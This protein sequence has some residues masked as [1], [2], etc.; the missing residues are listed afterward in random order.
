MGNCI[1]KYS[2]CKKSE[3]YEFEVT[4]IPLAPL[5]SGLENTSTIS[6]NSLKN[7]VVEAKLSKKIENSSVETV[8]LKSP[9][10]SFSK[11]PLRD[12]GTL[13]LSK[14]SPANIKSLSNS[15]NRTHPNSQ[16]I[17]T[18][19]L[20]VNSLNRQNNNHPSSVMPP[21]ISNG[22]A[23]VMVAIFDYHS[24]TYEELSLRKGEKVYVLNNM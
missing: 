13:S 15:L 2:L 5:Q 9:S 4:K 23:L 17:F 24:R 20:G 3:N 16:D 19:D 22:G 18:R 7:H 8:T 1:G 12:N 6:S 21:I 14:S 10:N 11:T